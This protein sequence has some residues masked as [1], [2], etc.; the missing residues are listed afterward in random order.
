MQRSDMEIK[1]IRDTETAD[2]YL[3]EESGWDI[4]LI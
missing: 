2:N 3:E 4:G 1:G